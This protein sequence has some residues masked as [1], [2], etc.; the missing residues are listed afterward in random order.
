MM[1]RQVADHEILK[2]SISGEILFHFQFHI[3]LIFFFFGDMK[4][5]KTNVSQEFQK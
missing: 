1:M 3:F 2:N 5:E 4:F